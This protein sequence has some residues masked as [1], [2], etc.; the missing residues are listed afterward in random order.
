MLLS[1]ALPLLNPLMTDAVVDVCHAGMGTLVPI[2]GKLFDLTVDLSALAPHDCPPISHYRMLARDRA[3][4]RRLEVAPGGQVAV[5]KALA[6]FSTEPDEA[7]DGVPARAL[8][9]S[10][11]SIIKQQAWPEF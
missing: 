4:L 3:W 6:L 10:V 9:V 8:R 5:G 1:L 2:G 11:A 7:L